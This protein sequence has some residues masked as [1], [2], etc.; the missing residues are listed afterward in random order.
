MALERADFVGLMWLTTPFLL[1]LGSRIRQQLRWL[2]LVPFLILCLAV[3]LSVPYGTDTA[4]NYTFGTVLYVGLTNFNLLVLEDP[5]VE[6]VRTRVNGDGEKIRPAFYSLPSLEQVRWCFSNAFSTRGIGWSWGTA[7]LPPAPPA[8]FSKTSFLKMS[9]RRILKQYLIHDIAGALLQRLTDGGQTSVL[10]LGFSLRSL[11]TACWWASTIAPMD[12]VYHI[13]CMIGVTSGLFWN[14]VEEVHPLKGAWATCYTLSNFW[15]RTWHQNFRRAL[16]TPSRYIARHVVR[17][18]K[19]SLM[20][21]QVQSHSAFAISGVYHWAAA[22]LAVPSEGFQQTAL[23]FA[24]MP[25]IMFLEDQVI[26]AAQQQLGWKSQ[27]WRYFGFLWTFFV[28][29]SLGAGFVD[30]CVRH[31]LV[32]SFPALPLS[33]TRTAL[34]LWSR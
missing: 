19:G 12:I 18:P 11:A 16:Q 24:V 6:H 7:R 5:Y 29:T 26:S 22:K 30:D 21:R 8:G 15:N 32:T 17:A 3:V 4:K 34:N 25:A 28:M 31:D 9:L 33:P 10:D 1:L 23:F 27:Q 2:L 14:V 20:S 13:V